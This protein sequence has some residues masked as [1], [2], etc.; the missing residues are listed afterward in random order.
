MEP[1]PSVTVT[2]IGNE[3]VCVGVPERRPEAESERPAGSVEAVLNVALPMAPDC[4]NCSLNAAAAVPV[5]LAGLVT[6]MVWQPM[7]RL[8]A[9]PVPVQPLPSVTLTTIG[10]VPTTIGVPARRPDDERVRPLG[11]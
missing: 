9:A 5:V 10:N 8:Y 1:L 6:V 2:T 11:S 3:P 4:V 7:T